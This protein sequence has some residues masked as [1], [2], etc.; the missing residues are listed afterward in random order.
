MLGMMRRK[1]RINFLKVRIELEKELPQLDAPVF[2]EGLGG[3]GNVG[4]LAATHLI[5]ELDAIKIANVYSPYFVRTAS[6]IPGIMY[7]D[8][9]VELLKD[10]IY[11]DPEENLMI[12][13]GP[14]Q[15]STIESYY[16]FAETILDFCAECGVRRI[17]TLGGYGTGRHVDEPKVYGVA[18]D[19]KL[20]EEIKNHG[21]HVEKGYHGPITGMAG[22][23]IG[24]GK[25]LGFEGI[26]LRGET[27]GEY[28]DPEAASAVFRALT[29]ILGI[30]ASTDALD[31]EIEILEEEM[32]RVAEQEKRRRQRPEFV[33]FDERYLGYV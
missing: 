26:C 11:Y 18:T 24:L 19:A 9:V 7:V 4:M 2:I 6:P 15:G 27:H 17:F 12:F 20:V 28:P 32:R 25:E 3:L 8:G 5:K 10:E 23:L 13:V 16:M 14:Y 1:K 29:S 22:L 33:P 30:K 21:V 31:R